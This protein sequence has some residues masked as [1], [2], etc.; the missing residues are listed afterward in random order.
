MKY[1]KYLIGTNY[2]LDYLIHS[3]PRHGSKLFF[4]TLDIPQA[5]PPSHLLRNILDKFL[6]KDH[7]CVCN[8]S[9]SSSSMES[10]GLLYLAKNIFLKTKGKVLLGTIFIDDDTSIKKVIQYP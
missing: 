5:V 8:F 1:L 4:H 9:G 6:E 2:H 7:F 3:V 10:C